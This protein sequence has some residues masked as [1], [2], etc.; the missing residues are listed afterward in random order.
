MCLTTP[1]AVLVLEM[2]DRAPRRA[3]QFLRKARCPE[4]NASVLDEAVLLMSELVT[5]AMR[6]GA[7]PITTEVACNATSGMQVRVSDGNPE[8][9]TA[10]DAGPDDQSGRGVHLVDMISDAWGVDPTPNGKTVW[11]RLRE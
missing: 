7:P 9:P 11:F 5:N 10:R 1:P 4:H 6:H 8:A 2:D 3:R